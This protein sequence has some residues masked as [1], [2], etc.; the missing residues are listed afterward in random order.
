MLLVADAHEI[1]LIRTAAASAVA[2]KCI[3]S[4]TNR[5]HHR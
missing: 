4:R 5:L 1:T 2:T 3:L